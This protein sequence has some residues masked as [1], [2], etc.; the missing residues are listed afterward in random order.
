MM[1][2]SENHVWR[3]LTQLAQPQEAL[4]AACANAPVR[5]SPLGDGAKLAQREPL[6]RAPGGAE[7]A[8]VLLYWRA[9]GAT[10]QAI[11]RCFQPPNVIHQGAVLPHLRLRERQRANAISR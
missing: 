2:Q 7:V 4:G 9:T 11:A 3:K 1:R 6:R 8:S 5:Q 10:E